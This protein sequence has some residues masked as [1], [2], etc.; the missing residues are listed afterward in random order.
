MESKSSSSKI[1][2]YWSVASLIIV[3]GFTGI[4]LNR[5]T[6]MCRKKQQKQAASNDDK[7]LS[8]VSFHVALITYIGWFM[9]FATIAVLPIDLAVSNNS[10]LSGTTQETIMSGF[11]KIF[12]WS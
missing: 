3:S 1:T 5:Y 4:L 8:Q 12:Y 9:G 6:G 7:K 11:W 10:D 2:F